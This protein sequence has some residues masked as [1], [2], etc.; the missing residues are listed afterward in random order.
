M[1][2]FCGISFSGLIG[3][4]HPTF[5]LL[6]QL[7]A[8]LGCGKYHLGIVKLYQVMENET[9]VEKFF[10]TVFLCCD[11][12]A[13]FVLKALNP[14]KRIA[15]GFVDGSVKVFDLKT[16]SVLQH[17]NGGQVHTNAVSSIDC[18]R[19]NNLMVTGSLDSTAKLYNS[20]TGKVITNIIPQL[21]QS[22]FFFLI[23]SSCALYLAKVLAAMKRKAQLKLSPFVQI[24]Q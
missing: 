15:I 18:H 24:L 20:Q 13:L 21:K 19:D 11:N 5:C 4:L 16:L 23:H 3:I 2:Q 14:G 6:E 12:F 10:Q 7:L 1:N 8:K 17:S 22:L 9:N